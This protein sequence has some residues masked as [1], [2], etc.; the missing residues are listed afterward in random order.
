M[1]NGKLTQNI[2]AELQTCTETI[3]NFQI[4]TNKLKPEIAHI[5]EDQ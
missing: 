3:K 4:R 1:E 2:Q 5:K